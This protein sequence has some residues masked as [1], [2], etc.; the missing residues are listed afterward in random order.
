KAPYAG[1]IWDTGR[2]TIKTTGKTLALDLLRHMVGLK[3]RNELLGEYR[4][5]LGGPNDQSIQLPAPLGV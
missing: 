5:T 3:A 2:S 1:V 4:R